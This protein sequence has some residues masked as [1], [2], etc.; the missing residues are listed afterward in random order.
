MPLSGACAN[1]DA[2]VDGP[3]LPTERVAT[4]F[5]RFVSLDGHGGTGLGLPTAQGIAGA[6]GG[7]L[8]YRDGSFVLRLPTGAIPARSRPTVARA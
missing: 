5:G 3:G 8:E 2:R 7:T 6:H 1:H 4:A